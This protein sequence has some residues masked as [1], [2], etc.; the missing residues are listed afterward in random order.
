MIV[1]AAYRLRFTLPSGRRD[2]M[3]YP[4]GLGVTL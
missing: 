2:M 4:R 1:C 3:L